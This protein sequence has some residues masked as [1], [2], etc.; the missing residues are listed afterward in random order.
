MEEN[1]RFNVDSKLLDD[2]QKAIDNFGNMNP[3]HTLLIL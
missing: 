3:W 1:S 2:L